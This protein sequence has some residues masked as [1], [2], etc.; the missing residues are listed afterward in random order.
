M[1]KV[2]SDLRQS[3]A[4]IPCF[5]KHVLSKILKIYNSLLDSHLYCTVKVLL[6]WIWGRTNRSKD[7]IYQDC[8][9]QALD[10]HKVVWT[11]CRWS[12]RVICRFRR[13]VSKVANPVSW[14]LSRHLTERTGKQLV[15][16]WSRE[17]PENSNVFYVSLQRLAWYKPLLG[18]LRLT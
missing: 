1:T 16:A 11:I 3:I 5:M 15:S 14:N 17:R 10:I 18:L 7:G 8:C 9:F 4:V 13:R 2:S 6:N 12:L